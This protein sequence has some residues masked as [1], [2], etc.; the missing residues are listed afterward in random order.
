MKISTSGKRRCQQPS[1]PRPRTKFCE[2]WS[3][4]HWVYAANVYPP[5]NQQCARF[6]DNSRL[7]SRIS[8][9]MIKQSTSGKRHYQLR[10]LPDQKNGE[11]W[12]TNKRVCAANVYPPKM[13]TARAVWAN[14]IALPADVLLMSKISA[15]VRKL[16]SLGCVIIIIWTLFKYI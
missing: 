14:A 5:K 3:I 9:E 2:L 8:P 15:Y 16:G 7:R 13:N 6:L 11:L 10:S 4:I 1:L 12:S